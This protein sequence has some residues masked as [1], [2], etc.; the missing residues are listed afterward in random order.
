[1]SNVLIPSTT[2]PVG[3]EGLPVLSRGRY[4][5]RL[6]NG[7]DQTGGVGDLKRAQQLRGQCFGRSTLDA[8]ALD[9]RCQH[10]LVEDRSSGFLVCCFRLLLLPSGAHLADSYASQR[11]D[12][13]SLYSRKGR[14]LELGRFCIH[15]DWQDAD[16]LRL[17]WGALTAFVDH[18]DVELL[19]GCSSFAGTRTEPYLHALSLLRARHQVKPEQGVGQPIGPRAA[20]TLHLAALELPAPDSKRA[21]QEMPPLLRSYLMMGGWVSDHVVVDRDLNTLHLFTGVDIASIPAAR[22][23]LLRA[24]AAGFDEAGA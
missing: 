19:F 10:M 2:I 7:V 11:Y 12:L 3:E 14:L 20:E 1:M 22:K 4:Q 5:A 8:D 23:R 24:V 13:R 15:P 18:H 17:A 16:I 21:L 9:S 6:I